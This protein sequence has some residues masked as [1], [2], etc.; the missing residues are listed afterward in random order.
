MRIALILAGVLLSSASFGQTPWQPPHCKYGLEPGEGPMR[1]ADRND[2]TSYLNKPKPPPTQKPRS[3]QTPTGP[4]AYD[5]EHP[6]PNDNRWCNQH[7]KSA[8]QLDRCW[9][10]Q[11]HEMMP[12]DTRAPPP[13][14]PGTSIWGHSEMCRGWVPS[15][16]QYVTTFCSS[17]IWSR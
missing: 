4:M 8:T 15:Q 14:A 9:R 13:A 17:S 6:P 1:C 10:R 3:A 2:P 16:Q 7:A 5:I 11:H 12:E